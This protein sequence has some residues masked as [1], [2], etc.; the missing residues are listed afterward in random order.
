MPFRTS[1]LLIDLEACLESPDEAAYSPQ[2][3]FVVI[4]T[5]LEGR[6]KSL[7]RGAA[8]E[9]GRKVVLISGPQE[10]VAAFAS[11]YSK[12]L[13]DPL[14]LLSPDR[15]TLLKYALRS[16]A[17]SHYQSFLVEP[18]KL[19]I[20]QSQRQRR[21]Y[22]FNDQVSKGLSRG[23]TDLTHLITNPTDSVSVDANQ[24]NSGY[25]YLI[26]SHKTRIGPDLRHCVWLLVGLEADL[27]VVAGIPPNDLDQML[28]GS[29]ER[30]LSC[31]PLERAAFQGLVAPI[32]FA[33]P[34]FMHASASALQKYTRKRQLS[35]A[36]SLAEQHAVK[37]GAARSERAAVRRDEAERLDERNRLLQWVRPG[38]R[39]LAVEGPL[40][41]KAGRGPDKVRR[42]RRT[43]AEIAAGLLLPNG[44]KE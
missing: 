35:A 7:L 38:D 11:A 37:L 18:C 22:H 33:P 39:I 4:E 23:W 13:S 3:A 41:V 10:A 2:T 12:E 21:R 8:R 19:T 6:G 9:D 34:D 28:L 5:Y 15:Y 26:L 1:D 40:P 14:T 29:R 30:L 32:L 27:I 36:S 31:R 16:P 44:L 25:H 20:S 17:V 24:A 43:K 42:I